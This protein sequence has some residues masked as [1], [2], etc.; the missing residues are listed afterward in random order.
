MANFHGDG[1]KEQ[2]RRRDDVAAGLVRLARADAVA[3]A[4]VFNSNGNVTHG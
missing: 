2:R 4:Q 3:L 1:E